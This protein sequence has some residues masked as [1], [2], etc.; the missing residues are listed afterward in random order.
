MQEQA[1]IEQQGEHPA[2][3]STAEVTTPQRKRSSLELNRRGR[4]SQNTTVE[5]AP[6]AAPIVP[7]ENFSQSLSSWADLS[8]AAR[9]FIQEEGWAADESDYND[10]LD[11]P[12]A[13]EA[14]K[15]EMK[16]RG[17]L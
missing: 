3:P 1:P 8:D 10:I 7:A 9:Q 11:D 16:C 17:L 5:V 13:E 6:T 2:T 4:R 12:A 15:N 14:L